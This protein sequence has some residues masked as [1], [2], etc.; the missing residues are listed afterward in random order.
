MRCLLAAIAIVAIPAMPLSVI[1]ADACFT[2]LSKE[3]IVAQAVFTCLCLIDWSQTIEIAQHPE[4][5]NE[6]NP[7]LGH[8]PSIRRVNALI[9]LG[10]ASHALITWSMPKEWRKWWQYTWIGIELQAVHVNW[11]SGISTPF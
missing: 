8:H 6:S 11:R 5:N 1:A 7:I 10:I 3:E 4:S 9:P 2:P